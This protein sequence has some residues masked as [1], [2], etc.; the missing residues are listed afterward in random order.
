MLRC[1]IHLRFRHTDYDD[2]FY[3]N[4]D[5]RCHDFSCFTDIFVCYID[6]ADLYRLILLLCLAYLLW[7]FP[8]LIWSLHMHTL[9]TIYHSTRHTDPLV[10]ILFWSSLSMIFVSPFVLII[11]FSLILCVYDISY[12]CLIAC[13][14]TILLCVIA[15]RLSMWDAH[16]SPYLSPSS[17]D[18]FLHYGSH[19]CKCETLCVL[20]LWP[21]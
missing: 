20:V 10:C 11:I 16:L 21:R 4:W 5:F 13:R 12:L 9:A 2:W 18:H 6:I 1:H 17:L 7:F 3:L 8:W 19:F 15:C 14:R